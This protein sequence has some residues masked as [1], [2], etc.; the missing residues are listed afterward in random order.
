MRS[1]FAIHLHRAADALE[2]HC[3][4]LNKY[5]TAMEGSITAD[6]QSV[7]DQ[8]A[9][10]ADKL[11]EAASQY[12]WSPQYKQWLAKNREAAAWKGAPPCPPTTPTTKNVTK[13]IDID[14]STAASF[15]STQTPTSET[16]QP[17]RASAGG[18]NGQGIT[19][20]ASPTT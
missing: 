20:A 16:M 1:P 10:L 17:I 19:E 6:I 3:V 2:I 13:S 15:G 18:S 5:A 14:A 4:L 8:S 12:D 9:Q 7:L 11:R